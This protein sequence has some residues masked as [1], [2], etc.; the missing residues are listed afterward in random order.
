MKTKILLLAMIFSLKGFS[1]DT[2][3]I[4][5]THSQIFS[6][7][8]ISKKVDK[9]NGLVVGV[10]HVENR[11]IAKQTING[12]NVEAN[13]APIA[14]ALIAF[15]AIMHLPDIIENKRQESIKA[16]QNGKVFVVENWNYTPNLKVNGLNVST[17]CFFTTT[18]MNGINIS[19]GNKFKN[20]NGLSISAL[21]TIADN[22][23]GFSVGLTNTNNNLKGVSAGFYNRTYNLNG[24]Q[25]GIFNSTKN[26]KGLQIGVSN[27]AHSRGIQLGIWNKNSKR[28][29]PLINW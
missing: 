1:Q 20:F 6:L 25:I 2:I 17:G 14:G 7:S 10:G 22:F 27:R 8:P 26:N 18:D 15:I 11:N 16:K 24:I 21:G 3:Q 19:V 13:P 12:I 29:L 9:V 28:S 4:S 5:N 23:N